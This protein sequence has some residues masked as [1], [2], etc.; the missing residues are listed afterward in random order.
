M[1]STSPIWAWERELRPGLLARAL[2]S[3]CPEHLRTSRRRS[4]DVVDF[5]EYAGP[6]RLESRWREARF[7]RQL[8]AANRSPVQ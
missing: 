5:W 7:L 8:L 4:P 1:L 6:S 3:A 2:D